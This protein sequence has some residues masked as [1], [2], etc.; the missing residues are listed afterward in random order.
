MPAIVDN[1]ISA[2]SIETP[3]WSTI[4]APADD[5]A[6]RHLEGMA[7][8]SVPLLATDSAIVDLSRLPGRT[9]VY[10]YP[11]S[12]RPGLPN[13]EGWEQVPGARGCTPQTCAFRDHFFDIKVLGVSQLFG[14]STQDTDYQREFVDRL[15]LPFQMLSDR[16]LKLTAALRLPTF[17][18]H[19][20]T[21]LKR[22]TMVI[23]NGVI[24][25]VF[26]PVFPPDEN[27]GEVL[28][29]LEKR[30]GR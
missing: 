29:W 10:S 17:E 16:D 7:V 1:T 4:P 15:Q 22:L 30:G 19:G 21:L 8:P 14:L 25:K 24:E 9:V 13:P 20:M 2:R 6:A 5:G 11:R 18:L 3:D 28:A 26:Y 12:G 23:K 27:P